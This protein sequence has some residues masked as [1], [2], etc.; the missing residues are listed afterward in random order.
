MPSRR[1]T[2]NQSGVSTPAELAG[3]VYTASGRQVRSRIGG[4]YGESM[5]T[6]RWSEMHTNDIGAN[7]G[8]R[9]TRANMGPNGYAQGG[10]DYNSDE[11]DDVE[12]ASSGDEYNA[13]DTEPNV[14]DDDE[15]VS[16][17]S[18]DEEDMDIRPSL[19]V[20]LRY[21]KGKQILKQSAYPS[22]SPGPKSDPVISEE[23]QSASVA[24]AE[25]PQVQPVAY[26]A[27]LNGLRNPTGDSTSMPQPAL[28]E[29][30]VAATPSVP[31]SAGPM[32]IDWNSSLPS[33][34]NQTAP[35]FAPA[36]VEPI[37]V[38][39]KVP[40]ARIQTGPGEPTLPGHKDAKIE[41][42]GAT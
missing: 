29:V 6:G 9:H 17:Q 26:P 1:S 15:D 32:E 24:P 12:S 40:P 4:A 2:R 22:P 42:N 31:S 7:G 5:L 28:P 38:D 18:M 11:V 30:A 41:Q 36:P 25:A 13:A 16:D 8:T 23:K 39:S 37:D 3:P 34:P 27:Q 33:A 20:Q 14:G 10:D 19:I 21:G 35:P